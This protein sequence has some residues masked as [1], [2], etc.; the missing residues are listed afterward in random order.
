MVFEGGDE[1]RCSGYDSY[2]V[3]LHSLLY[4]V[5]IVEVENIEGLLENRILSGIWRLGKCA[6][7]GSFY[8]YIYG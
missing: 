3:R 6:T 2:L 5:D 7:V 1:T 4:V 8:R